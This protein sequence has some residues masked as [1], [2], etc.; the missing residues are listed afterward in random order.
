MMISMACRRSRCT[1][2]FTSRSNRPTWSAFRPV[3]ISW[4]PVISLFKLLCDAVGD[5][6]LKPTATGNLPRKTCRDVAL[7]FWGA[8]KYG[9]NSR[10]GEIRSEPEF[11]DL[12]VTRLLA[13][14]AGLVR[15]YQGQFI[16]GKDCRKL[17]AEHGLAGVYPRL[18]QAF[19][20]KFNWAFRDRYQAI[21]MVQQSF[22]FTL[23]LLKRYGTTWR[24]STFYEDC[25]LTAFPQLLREIRPDERGENR[26]TA[27]LSEGSLPAAVGVGQRTGGGLLHC[28]VWLRK[29]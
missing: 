14:S 19:A 20:L 26:Q 15:N 11:V 2:S 5:S 13:E 24:S 6:G 7:A 1:V 22:L 8:E 21:P 28:G 27:G 12:H 10:Y 16:L 4:A 9:E 3:S 17:L 29:D 23:H 18:F 25:F